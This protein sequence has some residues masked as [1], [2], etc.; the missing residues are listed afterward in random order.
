MRVRLLRSSNSGV[1]T[2]FGLP[3]R[4][5]AQCKR[6]PFTAVFG[7]VCLPVLKMFFAIG[8]S[9]CS[10]SVCDSHHQCEVWNAFVSRGS[11]QSGQRVSH[12]GNVRA[13]DE[14]LLWLQAS[15]SGLRAR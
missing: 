1:L 11:H 8:A 13:E 6:L 2:G 10:L 9:A 5:L 14:V 3:L 4:H 7:R 12:G 15:L